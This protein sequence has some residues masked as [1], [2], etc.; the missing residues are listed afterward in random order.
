MLKFGRSS[1]YLKRDPSSIANM[2][3]RILL[4]PDCGLGGCKSLGRVCV[5]LTSN[6]RRPRGV[7]FWCPHLDST[8]PTTCPSIQSP[9]SLFS[10]SLPFPLSR[11]V[12]PSPTRL[13]SC[14]DTGHLPS[15]RDRFCHLP[16]LRAHSVTLLFKGFTVRARVRISVLVT[17]AQPKIE[18]Y[19]ISAS[20][21]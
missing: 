4:L 21:R 17:S 2:S 10:F 5:L 8:A 18:C 20:F 12:R 16:A 3:V 1:R 6:G 14:H 11:C 19:A 13:S 9:S 15:V 7:G